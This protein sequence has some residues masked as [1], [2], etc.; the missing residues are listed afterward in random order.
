MV[1]HGHQRAVAPEIE[2]SLHHGEKGRLHLTVS[3]D[4]PHVG[5][6]LDRDE[7]IQFLLEFALIPI[8]RRLRL[9]DFEKL[10]HFS[11]CRWQPLE[12]T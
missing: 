12:N 9:A 6:R 4:Q 11:Q 3:K 8:R 10:S 5:V 7:F 1:P 2:V